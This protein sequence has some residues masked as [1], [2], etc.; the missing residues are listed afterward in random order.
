MKTEEED[1]VSLSEESE[2]RT[3]RPSARFL[4]KQFNT[5]NYEEYFLIKGCQNIQNLKEYIQEIHN[6]QNVM[7]HG[8]DAAD[9][10]LNH[11][12]HQP[13]SGHSTSSGRGTSFGK[14]NLRQTM[15]FNTK[16]PILVED[17]GVRMNNS[18]NIECILEFQNIDDREKWKQI[19][20]T[21]AKEINQVLG[22]SSFSEKF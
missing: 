10:F 11:N 1:S 5:L 13:D 7:N 4:H 15:C 3:R 6:R 18:M 12:L 20:L 2:R 21:K 17:I 9:L 22:K 19:I 8:I 14:H 16:K